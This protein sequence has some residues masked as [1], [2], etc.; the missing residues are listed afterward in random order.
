VVLDLLFIGVTIAFFVASL[1]YVI[2]C[3]R[4]MK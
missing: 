1:G 4:L 2:V 3:D